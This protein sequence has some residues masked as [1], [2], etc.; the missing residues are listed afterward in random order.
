MTEFLFLCELSLK[1]NA[2]WE[3]RKNWQQAVNP[4][5]THPTPAFKTKP[6]KLNQNNASAKFLPWNLTWGQHFSGLATWPAADVNFVSLSLC[7]SFCL[8]NRSLHEWT[9]LSRMMA[10]T[11][12]ANPLGFSP[13]V[14]PACSFSP[15]VWVYRK[16]QAVS[17]QMRLFFGKAVGPLPGDI[18]DGLVN[19]WVERQELGG[20][21]CSMHCEYATVTSSFK[22]I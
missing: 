13:Y 4:D 2:I 10:K 12:V 21:M 3:V 9:V 20:Y 11:S 16:R 7:L 5:K 14:S 22:L 17:E 15:A 19:G 1:R 18:L 6:I 8:P